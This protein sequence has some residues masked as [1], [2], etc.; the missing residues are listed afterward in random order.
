[1]LREPLLFERSACGVSGTSR[2][3]DLLIAPPMA[4]SLW[5]N[6]SA[7]L[8]ASADCGD[9]IDGLLLWATSLR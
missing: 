6:T 8:R 3:P 4:E 2:L 5:F 1:M 9:G 7:M